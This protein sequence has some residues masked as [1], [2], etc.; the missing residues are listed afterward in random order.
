ME[1]ERQTG[2][3]RGKYKLEGGR[4]RD[5]QREY[6]AYR[7]TCETERAKERSKEENERKEARD[8]RQTEENKSCSG[9]RGMS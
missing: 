2:R 1:Q 9:D 6:D 5:T 3:G 4:Y 7:D 8:R